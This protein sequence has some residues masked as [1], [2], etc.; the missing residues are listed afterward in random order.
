MAVDGLLTVRPEKL[1]YLDRS[2]IAQCIW[3]RF[4]PECLCYQSPVDGSRYATCNSLR[5][6]GEAVLLTLFYLIR[7]HV[8]ILFSQ[9]ETFHIHNT[10][11]QRNGLAINLRF[12][13]GGSNTKWRG[14]LMIEMGEE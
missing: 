12:H 2:W 7:Q 10:Y 3:A 13:E 5:K 9:G 8:L 6:H 4:M 11:L 14:K 1:S